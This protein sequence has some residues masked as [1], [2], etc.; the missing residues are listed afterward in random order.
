MN[1]VNDLEK[2]GEKKIKEKASKIF[3][4]PSQAKLSSAGITQ[5]TKHKQGLG[6]DKSKK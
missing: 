5:V 2:K 3:A 1:V 4:P 6:G